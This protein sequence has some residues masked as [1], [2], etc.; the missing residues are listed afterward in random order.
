MAT[1]FLGVAQAELNLHI[2]RIALAGREWEAGNAPSA[3]AILDEC[4]PVQRGWEW[5]Y[6]K[7]LCNVDLLRFPVEGLRDVTLSSDAT[8]I[9]TH[10]HRLSMDVKGYAFIMDIRDTV[11]GEEIRNPSPLSFGLAMD[12]GS[13][14]FTPDGKGLAAVIS[15]YRSR[16]TRQMEERW[17]TWMPAARAPAAVYSS[18]EYR[19]VTPALPRFLDLATGRE[20]RLRLDPRRKSSGLVLARRVPPRRGSVGRGC[21]DLTGPARCAGRHRSGA[22]RAPSHDRGDMGREVRKAVTDPSRSGRMGE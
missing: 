8:R 15:G 19:D 10:S 4:Q 22:R 18:S 20:V 14:R 17:W 9:A 11:T 6:T 13:M 12:A 7:R 3:N 1:G 2:N 5:H 21:A 16:W